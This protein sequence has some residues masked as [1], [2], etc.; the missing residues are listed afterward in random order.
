MSDKEKKITADLIK[1][2]DTEELN[3]VAANLPDVVLWNELFNRYEAN[4]KIVDGLE[5]LVGKV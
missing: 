1:G 2:M 3:L 4:R 5:C